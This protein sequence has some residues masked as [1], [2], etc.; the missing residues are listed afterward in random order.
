MQAYVYTPRAIVPIQ[1]PFCDYRLSTGPTDGLSLWWL[2]NRSS[3]REPTI[4]NTTHCLNGLGVEWNIRFFNPG[5]KICGSGVERPLPGKQ[6]TPGPWIPLYGTV[7]QKHNAEC[8][9]WNM[10]KRALYSCFQHVWCTFTKRSDEGAFGGPHGPLYWIFNFY[11][12]T[13]YVE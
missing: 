3:S 13:S 11:S 2:S 4:T 1:T 8:G 9:C 5:V 7:K 12:C 6:G 10:V